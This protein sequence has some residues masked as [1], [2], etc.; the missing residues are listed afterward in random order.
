MRDDTYTSYHSI[1]ISIAAGLRG[2]CSSADAKVL[3][4]RKD[5]LNG[6]SHIHFNNAGASPTPVP[7]VEAMKGFLDAEAGQSFHELL[8]SHIKYVARDSPSC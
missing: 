6:D 5:I 2:L 8:V 3:S 1:T 4:L 7:I